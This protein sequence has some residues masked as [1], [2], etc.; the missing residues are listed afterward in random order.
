MF[1]GLYPQNGYITNFRATFMT[2]IN[3]MQL[4]YSF[5]VRV[6]NF[7]PSFLWYYWVKTKKKK[8]CSNI[9]ASKTPCTVIIL[10]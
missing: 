7:E 9:E 4:G 10:W 3:K 6:A 5:F 2:N 1:C 8:F